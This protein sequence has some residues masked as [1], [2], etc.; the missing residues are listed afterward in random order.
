M[1][2]LLDERDNELINYLIDTMSLSENF[3]AYM[4]LD[5][6]DSYGTIEI[7]ADKFKFTSDSVIVEMSAHIDTES[8]KY[9]FVESTSLVTNIVNYYRIYD[10]D[11]YFLLVF[12]YDDNLYIA[13][14]C[15]YLLNISKTIT[16]SFITFVVDT[17]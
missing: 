2:K 13:T 3:S 6:T 10:G 7:F 8:Q 17:G 11:P 1:S 15:N 16:D 4:N 12:N 5:G 14:D 9:V